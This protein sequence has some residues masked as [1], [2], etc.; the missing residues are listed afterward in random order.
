[1]PRS[2]R[3]PGEHLVE[4][5]LDRLA[6]AEEGPRQIR[7]GRARRSASISSSLVR[8]LVHASGSFRR[9][10]V[11]V[12]FTPPAS[13]PISGRPIRLTTVRISSGSAVEQRLLQPGRVG[14]RL[15]ERGA[16]RPGLGD[17]Q[18][19]LVELGDELAAQPERHRHARGEPERRPRAR[20]RP[21]CRRAADEDRLVDPLGPADRPACRAPTSPA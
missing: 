12:R 15:V 9:T 8:A 17:D 3:T 5:Q 14:D 7:A 2:A 10:Q 11:S 16:R 13:R 19:P 21:G 18:V 20:P 6:E 4:P 1:M